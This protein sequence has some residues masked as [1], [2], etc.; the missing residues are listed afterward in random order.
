MA[1]KMAHLQEYWQEA[2]ICHWLLAGVLSSSPWVLLARLLLR[3][4]AADFSPSKWFKTGENCSFSLSSDLAWSPTLS[5]AQSHPGPP[6]FRMGG[7]CIR[8]CSSG[9]SKV[10][11]LAAHYCQAHIH[12]RCL[13]TRAFL[14][15]QSHQYVLGAQCWGWYCCCI[16]IVCIK[17]NTLSKMKKHSASCHFYFIEDFYG[18]NTGNIICRHHTCCHDS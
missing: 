1:S 4:V 17:H 6:L 9:G 13:I 8:A 3:F 12:C 5:I 10:A 18:T 7:N 15:G 2:S 16:G 11:V 14:I